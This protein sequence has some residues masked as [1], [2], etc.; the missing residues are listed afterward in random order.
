MREKSDLQQILKHVL[1][2]L[3]AFEEEEFNT[4]EG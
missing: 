3:Q 2:S 4:N 1:V